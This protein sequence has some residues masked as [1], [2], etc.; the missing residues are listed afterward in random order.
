MSGHA[1][2]QPPAAAP[3]ALPY[4]RARPPPRFLASA[5]APARP[6]THDTPD[7]P[8]S[9]RR[10]LSW[11][12]VASA[13]SCQSPGPAGSAGP[14]PASAEPCGFAVDA[15]L[16]CLPATSG[17]RSSG[18]EKPVVVQPGRS[19][20]GH[21]LLLPAGQERLQPGV[22]ERHRRDHA[23]PEAGADPPRRASS[24][25]GPGG[26]GPGTQAPGVTP[27]LLQSH[28]GRPRACPS[29]RV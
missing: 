11:R 16:S 18:R 27:P 2:P 6:R 26:G 22:C 5:L 1:M 17:Q 12:Q 29:G 28:A 23:L 24:S 20:P 13:S 9:P 15:P 8:C 10:P 3:S 25:A 14:E 4:P 7:Q 19:R 21:A